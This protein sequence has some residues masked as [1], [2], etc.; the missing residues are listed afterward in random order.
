[1]TEPEK[2]SMSDLAENKREMFDG[3]RA[4]HESE[5]QHAN[6]AITMLLAIS[7]AVGAVVLTMLSPQDAPKHMSL[8]AWWLFFVTL[9]FSIIIALSAHIKI[10]ADH[11]RYADF[12]RE[13]VK[14]SILLGFY[15]KQVEL[16]DNGTKKQEYLKISQTIGQG[17]GYQLTQGIIWAFA[18]MLIVVTFLFACF[19][20]QLV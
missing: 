4:Y 20:P 16:N 10:N 19:S 17:T 9:T 14:T 6:H 7:G 11:S 2:P 8:V 5:I 3:M 13:Y 15:E 12:G 1:M 18:C